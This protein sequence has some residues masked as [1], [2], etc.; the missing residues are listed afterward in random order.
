MHGS[1]PSSNAAA[2]H[3]LHMLKATGQM[4]KMRNLDGKP[5]NHHTVHFRWVFHSFLHMHTWV[6]LYP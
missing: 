1:D 4:T 5:P 6:L 2:N 3:V